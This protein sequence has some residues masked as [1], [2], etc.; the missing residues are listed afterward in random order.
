MN[1]LPCRLPRHLPRLLLALLTSTLGAWPAL[2]QVPQLQTIAHSAYVETTGGAGPI[3]DSHVD[4]LAVAPA[5]TTLPTPSGGYADVR[6]EA[7]YGLL[8]GSTSALEPATPA[9]GFVTTTGNAVSVDYVTVINPTLAP[10]DPVDLLFTMK[11]NGGNG[12]TPDP[13]TF[14]PHAGYCDYDCGYPQVDLSLCVLSCAYGGSY[15]WS[16][17]RHDA[18]TQ[19]FVVHAH[20]G[21]QLDF[22]FQ[23]VLQTYLHGAVGH[24]AAAIDFDPG[25]SLFIDAALPGTELQSLSG[26][27]YALSAV[28]EPAPRWLLAGALLVLPCIARGATRAGAC[29]ARAGRE[30]AD[31]ALQVGCGARAGLK[32]Y[33]ACLVGAD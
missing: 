1:R 2:A 3:T 22:S 8:S 7:R 19:T 5:I 12:I 28:P 31:R 6:M 16:Y 11:V 13:V 27:D 24:N 23:L 33:S 18:D 9:A 14:T 29:G 10:G 4:S 15:T 17:A 32:T 26:H 25:A 30:A 20:V 21:Q